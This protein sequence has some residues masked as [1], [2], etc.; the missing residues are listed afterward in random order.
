MTS[1][2]PSKIKITNLRSECDKIALYQ[3]TKG[4]YKMSNNTLFIP[5]Y[6]LLDI[7]EASTE[8]LSKHSD[9]PEKASKLQNISK[10]IA[11]VNKAKKHIPIVTL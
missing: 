9:D 7:V 5:Q 3:E 1:H 4:G 10:K 2:M 6:G 11:K 8:F